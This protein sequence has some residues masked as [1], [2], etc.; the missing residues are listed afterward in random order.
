MKEKE[1]ESEK[2]KFIKKLIK[3]DIA[4]EKANERKREEFRLYDRIRDTIRIL[5]RISYKEKISILTDT[6][7]QKIEIQYP[8]LSTTPY[9]DKQIFLG[10]ITL[11]D[12]AIWKIYQESLPEVERMVKKFFG[13]SQDAEDV[14][15]DALVT[16]VEKVKM[17]LFD[18]TTASI[19]TYLYEIAKRKWMNELKLSYRKNIEVDSRLVEEENEDNDEDNDEY[20]FQSVS[21][22]EYNKDNIEY[23]EDFDTIEKCLNELSDS[24]RNLIDKWFYEGKTWEDIAK[25][26]N[27]AN[28]ATA[29]QQKYKCMVKFKE[30]YK[31]HKMN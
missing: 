25:E 27:Y 8:G 5:K 22:R 21:I 18:D 14:F 29:S 3:N 13:N 24:C 15:Q 1:I 30:I 9:S 31:K 16:L 20:I 10:L 23:P 6:E 19:N 7:F 17:G 26:N 12:K 28:A 4:R 11:N 2:D